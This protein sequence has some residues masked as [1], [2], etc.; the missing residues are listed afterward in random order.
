MA[1]RP[2][3]PF[4]STIFLPHCPPRICF[5]RRTAVSR[6][7][8][9][10]S[11]VSSRWRYLSYFS[12]EKVF[13]TDLQLHTLIRL[14]V[15]LPSFDTSA[16]ME[17]LCGPQPSHELLAEP[18]FEPGSPSWDAGALTTTPWAHALLEKSFVWVD[19]LKR[20]IRLIEFN[21]LNTNAL[22]CFKT[23]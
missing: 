20:K 1:S 10:A 12:S 19:K 9:L 4:S 3:V 17:Y 16:R 8:Q 13:V 21:R 5:F 23:G 15:S 18:R 7:E 14:G 11:R 6:P 22:S 2:G